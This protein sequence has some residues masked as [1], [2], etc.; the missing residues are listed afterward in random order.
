MGSHPAQVSMLLARHGMMAGELYSHALNRCSGFRVIARVDTVS[1]AVQA[2]HSNEIQIALI[3]ST[4]LDG[5]LSG[6]DALQQIRQ[7]CP[8]VKSVLLLERNE[9]HLATI[10]FRAGAKGVFSLATDGLKM[11]SRCVRQVSAGQIW[12]N[13]SQLQE[14]MEAFSRRA[15][16]QVLN[17]KGKQMLTKREEEVVQLVADGLTNR[18]I[19]NE[20]KISEHT[21]RNSLFRIFDKLGVSTRVEL[22]LST[23]DRSKLVTPEQSRSRKEMAT[24]RPSRIR[25]AMAS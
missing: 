5:P 4:L 14:V 18:Q 9:G 16:V 20:L 21:V 1:E 17:A 22:A 13:S 15:R 11:L 8:G 25:S 23:V 2:V 3:S 7:A 24:A 6:I 10:A 12:A 19:A